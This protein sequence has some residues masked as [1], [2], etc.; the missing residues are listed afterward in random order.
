MEKVSKNCYKGEEI[1]NLMDLM[2]LANEGKSVYVP[3]WGVKPAAVIISMRFRDI[4]YLVTT[5]QIF[6]IYK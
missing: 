5:K 4:A 6:Y 2:R 3:N 1:S